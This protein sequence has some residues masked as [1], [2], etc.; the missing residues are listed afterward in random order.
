M[1]YVPVEGRDGLAEDG[2]PSDPKIRIEPQSIGSMKKEVDGAGARRSRR[3]L[4][5]AACAGWW[6]GWGCGCVMLSDFWGLLIVVKLWG[7]VGDR[8][9]VL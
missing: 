2:D 7:C 3:F 8:G 5:A 9:G 1:R 6:E 4:Y